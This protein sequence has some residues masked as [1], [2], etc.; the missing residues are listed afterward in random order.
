M[1]KILIKQ[2]HKCQI[3]KISEIIYCKSSSNYSTIYLQSQNPITISKCLSKLAA[4]LKSDF[5][6]ISQSFLVN[7][8]HIDEIIP[9]NKQILISTGDKLDFTMK[10]SEL[11][12]FLEIKF[13][14]QP[15]VEL[16]LN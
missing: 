5:V 9:A 3:I 16:E 2:K 15:E 10:Y 6:R 13:I 1:K 7:I 14:A 8:H 12:D 11:I 4:E